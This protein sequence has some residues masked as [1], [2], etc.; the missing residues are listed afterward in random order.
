VYEVSLGDT[1]GCGTPDQ[2]RYI[3]SELINSGIDTEKLAVHFHNTN[4]LAIQNIIAALEFGIKT[5][6]SSI[7]GLGGC[8][9]ANLDK[10]NKAVGNV[11]T[12]EVLKLVKLLN[13]ELET[14]IDI[15]KIK[16]IDEW[17]RTNLL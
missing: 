2:I 8:P 5:I 15:N 14:E 12:L 10:N 16:E 17:T 4:G 13:L 3:I 11:S 9:Y 1:I 7:G 6:D